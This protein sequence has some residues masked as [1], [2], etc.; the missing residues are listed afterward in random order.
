MVVKVVKFF[1]L[2]EKQCNI[3]QVFGWFA[4][5]CPLMKNADTGP[6]E[7]HAC[8]AC[9]QN[10]RLWFNQQEGHIRV[11]EL[12]SKM[13][14][15]PEILSKQKGGAAKI[16]LHSIVPL[17]DHCIRWWKHTAGITQQGRPALKDNTPSLFWNPV[18]RLRSNLPTTENSQNIKCLIRKMMLFCFVLLSRWEEIQLSH[19]TCEHSYWHFFRSKC[20]L[21]KYLPP[22]RTDTAPT[23]HSESRSDK[24]CSF[25][26]LWLNKEY[27]RSSM[28]KDA[29]MYSP[30]LK[31]FLPSIAVLTADA[32]TCFWFDIKIKALMSALISQGIFLLHNPTDSFN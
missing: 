8:A 13:M 4:D 21:F 6:Y 25:P 2:W 5:G 18:P 16:Y 15:H 9:V 31:P 32:Q 27:T 28:F 3:L 30:F 29:C 12:L 11:K 22:P 14:T 19:F 10:K 24:C 23:F 20:Y 1:I 17:S 7:G 26:T